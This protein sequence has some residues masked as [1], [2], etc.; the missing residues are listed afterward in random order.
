MNKP[1]LTHRRIKDQLIEHLDADYAV[2]DRLPDIRTLA[3]GMKVGQRNTFRAVRELVKD[4][5]LVSRPKLGTYVRRL[6]KNM[7]AY[8]KGAGRSGSI[9]SVADDDDVRSEANI[10]SGRVVRVLHVHESARGDDFI[11]AMVDGFSQKIEAA[12]AKAI[13]QSYNHTSERHNLGHH[14]LEEYQES[15]IA[16]FNPSIDVPITSRADQTVMVISTVGDLDLQI[17]GQYDVVCPDEEHGGF[18]AGQCLRNAGHTTSCFIGCHFNSP[19]QNFDHTSRVRMEGF[20]KGLASRESQS[21]VPLSSAFYCVSEGAPLVNEYMALEPRPRAVF[22]ASDE[23]AVGFVLGALAHGLEPGRDYDI[24]GFDGQKL[25]QTMRCGPLTT[26]AV[27]SR[28]MGQRAAELLTQRLETPG[29]PPTRAS[30][31]C[32][33]LPGNTVKKI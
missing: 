18:L 11:E 24:I 26:I 9:V 8:A 23:L 33:L 12:G 13:R 10:L 1:T 22:A 29:H 7:S 16:T 14:G 15:I 31:G 28:L 32:T 17:Q 3:R 4:G 25:G 19:D 6:P 30:L 27:P 5:C 20:R 2:G 21:I